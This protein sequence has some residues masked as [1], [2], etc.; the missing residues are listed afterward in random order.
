MHFSP[1]TPTRELLAIRNEL[2]T[3]LS[4]EQKKRSTNLNWIHDEILLMQR[5]ASSAAGY[6]ISLEEIK[7]AEQGAL[8]HS[9]YSRKFCL[10]VAELAMKKR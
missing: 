7:K 2:L 5:L 9:D 4:K 1:S 8:G 10:Y 3:A 6:H